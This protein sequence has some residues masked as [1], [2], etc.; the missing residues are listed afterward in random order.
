MRKMILLLAVLVLPAAWAF[1]QYGG[2]E[3]GYNRDQGGNRL[4]V[5]GCLFGEPGNLALTDDQGNTFE[6]RGRMASR[7]NGAIGRRVRVEGR[8]WFDADNPNAMSSNGEVTPSLRV[9]EIEQVRGRCDQ[10]GG[11]PDEFRFSIPIH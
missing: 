2:Y 1:A 7:L 6:L 9:F 8:T 3:R 10:W 4:R 5:E 11:N